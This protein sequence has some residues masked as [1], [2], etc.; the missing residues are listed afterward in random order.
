MGDCL[1]WACRK[2][3]AF[4]AGRAWRWTLPSVVGGRP[5]ILSAIAEKLKRRSKDDFKAR[6][7][8][9][10]EPVSDD[11]NAGCRQQRIDDGCQFV[12]AAIEALVGEQP[13]IR[14]LDNA[15][16]GAQPGAV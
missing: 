3:L 11:E 1:W 10:R 5:M 13:G 9:V 6:F 16:N 4:T 12:V 15:A 8:L 7:S 2:F 14:M